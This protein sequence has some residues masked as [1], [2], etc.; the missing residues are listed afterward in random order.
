MKNK[1]DYLLKDRPLDISLTLLKEPLEAPQEPTMKTT[2]I[3]IV[4]LF[5]I[6]TGV[7]VFQ[8]HQVATSLAAVNTTVE[9]LDTGHLHGVTHDGLK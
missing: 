6:L 4:A 7:V 1:R 2:I 9:T 5:T 3:V 8:L